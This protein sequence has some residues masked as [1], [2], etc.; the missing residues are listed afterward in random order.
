[1]GLDPIS[2]QWPKVKLRGG[3]IT[4]CPISWKTDTKHTQPLTNI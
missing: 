3:G 1:M 4:V 2:V